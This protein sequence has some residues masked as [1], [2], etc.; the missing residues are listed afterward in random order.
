M[1]KVLKWLGIVLGSLVVLVLVAAVGLFLVGNGRVSRNYG[2]VAGEDVSGAGGTVER[3]E[4]LV[5]SVSACIDCHGQAFEGSVLIDEA[6]IGTL[7][8]SNLTTGRG[9]VAG[10]YTSDAL[11]ERA[12]R[13][14]VGAD[15]RALL[16][17]PAQHYT[18]FSDEDTASVIAYIKSRAPVDNEL[19]TR[20]LHPVANIMLAAGAFGK[21][22]AEVIDHNGGHTP[23][24]ARGAT[25]EYG[26]YL[27]RVGVCADCHGNDY[28]GGEAGGGGAA[29]P[30]IT[31][32]GNVGG[33]TRDQFVQ[34]IRT[35][36]RPNGEPL[37]EDM[38]WKVYGRMTDDDLAALHAYLRTLP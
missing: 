13:H 34:T 12:L 20:A 3:G 18:M 10:Q 27:A 31:S 30:N 14:G 23:P 35:G 24:A 32:A 4:Y 8:A 1:R 7:A 36:V 11:W 22:P 19:P 17:M 9:G 25:A 2:Q 37:S 21:L 28:T 5:A 6:P 33:W 29:A 38:P 26:A 15:G 16:I